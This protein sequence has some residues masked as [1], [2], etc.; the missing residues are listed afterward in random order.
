MES[1]AG[2]DGGVYST[3]RGV[4]GCGGGG[5]WGG[6]VGGEE[7]EVSRRRE[8][9]LRLLESSVSSVASLSAEVFEKSTF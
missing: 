2:D 1:A 5:H 6:G 3:V 9:T 8:G 7:E 4:E